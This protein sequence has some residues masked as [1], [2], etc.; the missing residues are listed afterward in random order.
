[1]F[2]GA[3]RVVLA[4][5]VGCGAS[6][7][8]Q[9]G[10]VYSAADYARAESFMDY[11][12]NPLVSHSVERV[13]W[14]DDGRF[15]FRDVGQEGVRY[16]L[17]DPMKKTK[18]EAFDQAKV[19][20]ALNAAMRAGKLPI[21]AGGLLFTIGHLPINDFTLED[22]DRTLILTMAMGSTVVRCD[23]RGKG[24][25]EAA[26]DMHL[27]RG[28][29]AFDL[30]PDGTK[31]AFI[32]WNNLWVRDVASGKLTQLTTDGVEGFG[33]ATDNAGWTH[34]S[35]PILE[36]SPDSKK[37]ATFQ[38][39]QVSVKQM[40][41]V[42]TSVGHPTV[43]TWHYP[44]PGDAD[45]GSIQPVV[46]D[47]ATHKMVRLKM[48]PEM[49]RSSLCDDVSCAGGHGWDDVQWSEDGAHLA[50]VSTSRDHKLESLRVADAESG[51]VRDVMSE[52]AATYFESG[53]FDNGKG[54]VSWRYLART[55]EVLW[56][57]ERD[58]WGQLY[59]Y[60]ATT[61]VMKNQITRGDGNVIQ[62]LRVDQ[63][64]RVIYFLAAGKEVG[65]DPYYAALY[66]VNFDGS[67]MKLLTPE[68]ANHEVTISP[69]GRY[70]VDAASTPMTPTTT[71]V[72]DDEGK[73]LM[74]V[75]HEDITNLRALG[76]QPLT[77]ITVKA[78]DGKTD[79]YGFL[80]KPTNFD[81]T[82]KYP[83]IDH[84]YPGPQTGSCGSRSFSA[85][86]K[87][88]QSLAELGFVVVCIDGMGT[89][90]RSKSFHDALYG[91]LGD[92]TIPDQIAGIKQ[93]AARFAWID[94][95]R[96]GIY[97]HS[98]GGAAA[99]AAMFH[100]PNFFKVGVSESG[101]HDNR[102][103]EDDWAEKWI[104]LLKI[105]KDKTTN[106]DSQANE[107]YVKNLKGHLLLV[108]GTMD[109][110]VPP[111]NTLLVA[112]A[113]IKANK[114]FDLLMVPNAGHDYGSATPYVMRRRWDYFVRYLADGE[115]PVDYALKSYAEQQAA[116]AQFDGQ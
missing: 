25:C 65:R 109:D 13:V 84:V 91:D 31:A 4:V 22:E 100:F 61:G 45:V 57:S 20:A 93:L 11:N 103:Y 6:G 36:W 43:E 96:V 48:P 104:G 83:V 74:E 97:G 29:E 18:G 75:E 107:N 69:N 7:A 80:F 112:D 71:V 52:R 12:V 44:M 90:G 111:N 37:I 114:D 54:V 3:G 116:L 115:P 70:F 99:A 50:F 78:R 68:D 87:D 98:G 105:N 27:G 46:I 77:Q 9:T 58:G 72:R 35:R 76:W 33:Y 2:G 19:A 95:D 39:D 89:A 17:I 64:A 86:H 21:T 108:H 26:G 15:W 59:L 101:N 32:R 49:H 28:W 5:L 41:L 14:L 23:L 51:E 92:N 94:V 38:L 73:L 113:L 47:V 30:S 10:R 40:T 62:A 42:G 79:L 63:K 106:Y 34:S 88:M 66:R 24:E 56:F 82:R 67:G 102:V 1:M 81:A 53:N 55:N 16:L 60:D 110:N 85:A 8:A